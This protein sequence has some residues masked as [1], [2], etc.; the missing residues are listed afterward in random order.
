[1][2]DANRE[3]GVMQRFGKFVLDAV[4]KT[5]R[6]HEDNACI[7]AADEQ[8]RHDM[9][10]LT[11]ALADLGATRD[12]MRELMRKWF[13]VD[14]MSEI[15]MYIREGAQVRFPIRR[16]HEHMVRDGKRSV[17]IMHF[18]DN[19]NVEERLRCDPSLAELET[20]ELIRRLSA[21]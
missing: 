20:D 16:I 12:Q 7:E 10:Q 21:Q 18:I 9:I 1:M 2:T 5:V 19:H 3:E 11:A 14:S 13:V 8:F 17:E 15:D 4:Q 6:E